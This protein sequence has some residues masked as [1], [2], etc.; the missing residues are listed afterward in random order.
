MENNN[1]K[2]FVSGVVQA[3][4]ELIKLYLAEGMYLHAFGRVLK[5]GSFIVTGST[6]YAIGWIDGFIRDL[7]SKEE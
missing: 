4:K 6:F 5:A 1:F 3:N 7:T 2:T